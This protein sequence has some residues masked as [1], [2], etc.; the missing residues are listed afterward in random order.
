MLQA[1]GALC[2]LVILGALVFPAE[3]RAPA[4]AAQPVE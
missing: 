3:D 2:V 1:S 4:P